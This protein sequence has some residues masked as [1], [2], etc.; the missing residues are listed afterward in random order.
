MTEEPPP[1]PP[2]P[3]FPPV[4]QPPPYQHHG[5]LPYRPPGQEPRSQWWTDQHAYSAAIIFSL[6]GLMLL[7]AVISG[8]WWVIAK[9]FGWHFWPF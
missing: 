3:G 6:M 8:V 1:P 5:Q 2:P 9:I 7:G 4:A